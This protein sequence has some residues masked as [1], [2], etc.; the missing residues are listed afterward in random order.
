MEDP[1]VALRR[2]LHA[3]PELRFAEHHTAARLREALES[4]GLTVTN[5]LARTGLLAT[6]DTGRPGPA[7]LVRADM[8]AYPVTEQSGLPWAS[9]TVGVSHAC[10]HD[11]HM[12]V[13]ATLMA[14]LA[15]EPPGRGSVTAVFQPAEEIPYGEASGGREMVDA[16]VTRGVSAD[17]VLGLH[18]WPDLALGTVGVDAGIAMAAK[19]SFGI[20]VTGRSAHAATPSDGRDAILAAAQ[21]VTGIHLAVQRARDPDELVSVNVGTIAGGASQSS[22]AARVELTGTIRTHSDEVMA[23]LVGV[24]ERVA[25]GA[26]READLE[27]TVEWANE[28]PAVVNDPALA[29]LALDLLGP[30]GRLMDRPALTTDDFALYRELA[31]SLYLK[32]GV[33]HPGNGPAAPLHSPFFRADDEAVAVGADA[34]DMLVRHLLTDEGGDADAPVARR[35]SGDGSHPGGGGGPDE[36]QDRRGGARVDPSVQRAG[37]DPGGRR[38]RVGAG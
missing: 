6:Y 32:L 4:S 2:A 7:V 31:P 36:P 34:L 22:L 8:D 17:A 23:R 24:V 10:G 12:A 33:T 9:T 11:V 1:G 5:G 37:G 30:R 18:C 14:R 27:V 35:L 13:V 15:V 29:R 25:E 26:A 28:M 20:V 21:L 3:R 38:T 19:R 16:L